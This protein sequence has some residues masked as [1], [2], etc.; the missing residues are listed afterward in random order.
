[1]EIT[2]DR[3]GDAGAARL[4]MKQ[5]AREILA[6]IRAHLARTTAVTV[7]VGT[8]LGAINQLDVLLAGSATALTWLKVALTYLVP[9]LVVN[10]GLLT[11]RHWHGLSSGRP[12]G[13]KEQDLR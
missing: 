3:A 1:M 8:T 13:T 12:P 9:F 6:I 5:A 2:D 7:V 4:V 11:G 10:Y